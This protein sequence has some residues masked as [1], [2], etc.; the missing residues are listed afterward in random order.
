MESIILSLAHWLLMSFVKPDHILIPILS[1]SVL[2]LFD[3]YPINLFIAVMV[4]TLVI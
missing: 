3:V 4:E 1:L 2:L